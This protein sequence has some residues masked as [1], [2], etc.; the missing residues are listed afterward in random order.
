MSFYL[1]T[2]HMYKSIYNCCVVQVDQVDWLF[3]PNWNTFSTIWFDV[4][5]QNFLWHYNSVFDIFPETIE[6][7]T[8]F[9]SKTHLHCTM[10]Q[11][12]SKCEFYFISSLL[13]YSILNFSKMYQNSS[14]AKW[15][16]FDTQQ[17]KN[18]FTIQKSTPNFPGLSD[19]K[20]SKSVK[21][22]VE[23]I[24]LIVVIF[25]LVLI[26]FFPIGKE[27]VTIKTPG[28]T[29]R[30]FRQK[31]EYHLKISRRQILQKKIKCYI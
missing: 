17:V 3:V 9:L 29:C 26:D 11:G 19:K 10:L 4:K 16:I 27:P 2:V 12:N 18:S 5:I 28:K 8:K 31:Y 15:N 14:M 13:F 1:V 24:S 30:K 22:F 6:M 23:S 21:I 20:A 25:F 7:L